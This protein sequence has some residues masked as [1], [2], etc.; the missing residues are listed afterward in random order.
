M[1]TVIREEHPV[2]AADPGVSAAAVVAIVIIALLVVFALFRWAGLGGNGG[3][4]ASPGV[5]ISTQGGG[6][7]GA[8]Y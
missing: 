8:A 2:R 5:N 6:T 7:D 1:A 3:N 4:D